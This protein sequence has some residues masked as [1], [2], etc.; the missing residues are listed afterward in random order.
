[1]ERSRLR[2]S[3]S[4]CHRRQSPLVDVQVIVRPFGFLTVDGQNK[5]G[6]A[7]AMH[8]LK[9]PVGN[10]KLMVTCE[11][12][13]SAGV[14]HSHD[15]GGA[16][17]NHARRA[18]SSPRCCR[19]TASRPRRW[20]QKSAPRPAPRRSRSP[21]PFRISTPPEGRRAMA[22]DVRYTVTLQGAT[23]AQDVAHIQPGKLLVV[24]RQP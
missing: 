16:G 7:L 12:C 15:L 5:S 13:E 18:G 8:L 14:A 21:V 2:T 9:L 11:D 17:A 3:A 20:S 1:M 10:H 24:R 19:S 6:D 23:I 22:H 4:R